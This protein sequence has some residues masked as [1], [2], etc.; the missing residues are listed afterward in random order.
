MSTVFLLL[1]GG[2]GNET[3]YSYSEKCPSLDFSP[4]LEETSPNISFSVIFLCQAK[5]FQTLY[6]ENRLLS[7]SLGI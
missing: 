2:F 1:H 4:K 7:V 6:S 5:R 3:G